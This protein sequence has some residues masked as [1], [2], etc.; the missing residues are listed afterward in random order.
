LSNVKDLI[1]PHLERLHKSRLN[2]DQ[3]ILV[4]VLQSNLDNIISPFIGNL[5]SLNYN[6]TP[7]EIKVANLVKEGRTKKGDC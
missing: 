2:T 7:T 4:S 5:S 3:Q 1:G 6:L